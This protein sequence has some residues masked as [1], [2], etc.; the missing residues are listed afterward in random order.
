[1]IDCNINTSFQEGDAT[2]QKD[3]DWVWEWSS[4]PEQLQ[5]KYALTCLHFSS[6]S[7]VNIQN[8][9][10]SLREWKFENSKQSIRRNQQG[11]SLRMARVGKNSLFSREVLYSLVLT[12]VLS[13][14]L[15]AGIGYVHFDKF[16]RILNLISYS[17]L[18]E[19]GYINEDCSSRE[20]RSN[21]N[22]RG[23]VWIELIVSTFAA[24]KF[25]TTIIQILLRWSNRSNYSALVR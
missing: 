19:L 15:G 13:L 22:R 8:S 23:S 24:N 4:R 18:L 6:H 3:N 2:A 12:N 11:Y 7:F 21:K 25:S 1:M 5:A 17:L 16:V 9:S 10:L 14:L 20:S